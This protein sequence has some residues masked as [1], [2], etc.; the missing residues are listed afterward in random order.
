MCGIFGLMVT[1]NSGYSAEFLRESLATLARCSESRGK[2]S[3]GLV[4]RDAIDKEFR[5]VKGPIAL[6]YLFGD[7]GVEHQIKRA[8]Q[9]AVS[10]NGSS[11]G[12]AVMGHTRLVTNGS[13]A[14]EF[15]NQ[16]VI[17]DGV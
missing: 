16:P 17:K 10:P 1:Q 3:S 2:D 8:V 13:Q 11:S 9:I 6:K 14:T 7:E 15:N 5:I 4:I 12:L